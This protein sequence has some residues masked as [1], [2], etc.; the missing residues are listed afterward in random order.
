[1]CNPNLIFRK[2]GV[3][4]MITDPMKIAKAINGVL[5]SRYEDGDIQPDEHGDLKPEMLWPWHVS[6]VI[7]VHTHMNGVGD[8]IWF[9][10][11]DGTVWNAY[12]ECEVDA[13][14]SDFDTVEN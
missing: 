3:L 9:R 5:L 10:L 2:K 8:G 12:G 1:M 13:E 6:Q 14:D 4:K 11:N 7:G